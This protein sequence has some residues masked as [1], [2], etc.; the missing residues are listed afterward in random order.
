MA[1]IA[2]L[3][4]SPSPAAIASATRRWRSTDCCRFGSSSPVL[5]D[6]EAEL[7]A[8]HDRERVH[9]PQ[10]H[11]VVRGLGDGQVEAGVGLDEALGRRC[12][13]AAISS[14]AARIAACSERARALRGQA[15]ERVLEHAPGL[16]QPAQ[17]VGVGAE[18]EP[19]GQRLVERRPLAHERAVPV[20]HLDQPGRL[21]RGEAL[22]HA[23]DRD[24]EPPGELR[25]A[26]Q[27]L[28]GRQRAVDDQ[29]VQ[30]SRDDARQAAATADRLDGVQRH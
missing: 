29:R 15:H 17:L 28:P 5:L 21:Q 8:Q 27:P 12:V 4:S 7:L 10:Q 16:V 9:Q 11:R 18:A 13:A 6:V 24:A 2:A 19:A 14:T 30:A 25:D 3:A 22:A 23:G 20:A 26:R 1:P